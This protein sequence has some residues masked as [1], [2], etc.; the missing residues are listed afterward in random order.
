MSVSPQVGEDRFPSVET[1][2]VF[3]GRKAKWEHSL[4]VFQRKKNER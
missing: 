3:T 4:V 2:L 1:V